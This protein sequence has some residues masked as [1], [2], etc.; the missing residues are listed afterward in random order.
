[1]ATQVK[2][3]RG[4]NAEILAAVPAIGELWYNTTD[5][6]IHMGDGVTEGGHKHININTISD[7]ATYNFDSVTS[8]S[9]SLL[10][11]DGDS[12]TVDGYASANDGAHG[13]WDV[14][15]ASSVTPNGI[16][17]VQ[18]TGVATLA[19][20][21]RDPL[22]TANCGAV[23]DGSTDDSALI[24]SISALGCFTF[25]AGTSRISSSI[26]IAGKCAFECGA[27][28]TIDSGATVTFTEQ[29]DADEF[30]QIFYG[31][32]DVS[33]LGISYGAW[34][35]GDYVNTVTV[36]VT[37]IQKGLDA[38]ESNGVFIPP[39]GYFTSDGTAL[40]VTKGQNI[41]GYATFN[42]ELR[43]NGVACNGFVFSGNVQPEIRNMSFTV[44]NQDN[45]P[46]EGVVLDFQA[47]ATFF[48][49]E[50]IVTRSAFVAVSAGVTGSV[51]SIE[52][53][54]SIQAGMIVSSCNDVSLSEFII[55]A[56]S[57]FFG[58]TAVSGTL[59][60]GDVI[61]GDTS[62]AT[63]TINTVLTDTVK[64]LEDT[65]SFISGENITVTSG[66]GV[67]S[68]ATLSS[69][70]RTH[71]LGGL[72]MSDKVE[73]FIVQQ[74]D[75]IGGV[76]SMTSTAASYA[77]FLRPAYNR[78]T[79]VYFD[80]ADEG[81]LLDK[82][83]SNRFTNCWFSNRPNNGLNITSENEDHTFT[84]CSF[85]NNWSNGVYVN[86]GAIGMRFNGCTFSGNNVSGGAFDG[87]QFAPG[88]TDFVVQGSRA[89][90]SLGFGTQRFGVH[91]NAG[92][93][94]RYIIADN[95]IAGNGTAGVQD[96]GTGVNKR[97][98]DNY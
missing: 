78:F 40:T 62:G 1:M 98:A 7:Y 63:S 74:G 34:F 94:D 14:V 38:C 10:V 73:A 2:H 24:E 65:I 59:N 42:S 32:G 90:G 47:G 29:P 91:V 12:V 19:L 39:K 44:D 48:K 67:G 85:I 76:Y 83:V 96:G 15:L 71:Q 35:M 22:T 50:N 49:A 21:L 58:V 17:I 70:T 37:E 93:S 72:R 6:T 69:I 95:L 57:T 75:I 77:P 52:M 56:P 54:D 25:S 89:G 55:S 60:V 27:K 41:N 81:V 26:T 3:R 84:N 13:A 33:G 53:L 66:T 80:S 92:S 97:V 82:S 11:S 28:L 16:N 8:A 4:T 9:E 61:Q 43:W 5:N 64:G 23:L 45:I 18:C 68:T 88:C 20:V 46:S 36:T 30:S 87:I 79:D 31:D 86:A 51:S